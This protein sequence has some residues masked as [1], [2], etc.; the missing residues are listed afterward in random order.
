[1]PFHLQSRRSAA[2]ENQCSPTLLDQFS[3]SVSDLHRHKQEDRPYACLKYTDNTYILSGNLVLCTASDL[4][5]LA[6]AGERVYG[7]SCRG[8]G[9]GLERDLSRVN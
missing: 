3:G 6:R 1:M 8:S 7:D 4:G 9:L 5:S 2:D